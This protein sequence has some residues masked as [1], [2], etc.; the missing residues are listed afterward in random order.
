MPRTIAE[1]IR[2]IHMFMDPNLRSFWAGA[3]NPT[4]T[5]RQLDNKQFPKTVYIAMK[6]FF[7]VTSDVIL[8]LADTDDDED[9]LS[10]AVRK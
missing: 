4:N 7:N 5:R 3:L 9:I 1:W 8:P 2:L 6:D 10:D